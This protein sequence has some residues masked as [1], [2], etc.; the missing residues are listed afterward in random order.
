MNILTLSSKVKCHDG[1]QLRILEN[2]NLNNEQFLNGLFGICG[3]KNEVYCMCSF[4]SIQ[5][6]NSKVTGLF[7]L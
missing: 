1:P 6:L 4:V 5:W 2:K 3:L 7:A